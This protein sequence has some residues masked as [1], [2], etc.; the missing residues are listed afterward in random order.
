MPN[1]IHFDADKILADIAKDP[2]GEGPSAAGDTHV[3]SHVTSSDVQKPGVLESHVEPSSMT[4]GQQLEPVDQQGSYNS[5]LPAGHLYKIQG[6]ARKLD[7]Q[8]HYLLQNFSPT[9]FSIDV[10]AKDVEDFNVVRHFCSFTSVLP[11][12]A[13]SNK[14]T[15]YTVEL[16]VEHSSSSHRV[17]VVIPSSF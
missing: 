12:N 13:S 11:L 8:E 7:V 5:G 1:V 16:H 14:Y 10:T 17:V 9:M 3:E 15:I 2:E 6:K 4:N